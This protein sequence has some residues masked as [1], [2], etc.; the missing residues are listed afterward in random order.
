MGNCG[1][2]ACGAWPPAYA[3]GAALLAAVRRLHALGAAGGVA[4][5]HYGAKLRSDAWG[6]A[7]PYRRR[8]RFS[9]C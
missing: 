9:G 3:W 4:T 6:E 8:R 5:R 7:L 1:F 2:N